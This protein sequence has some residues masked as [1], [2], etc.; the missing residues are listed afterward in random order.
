MKNA[1]IPGCD[2]DGDFDCITGTDF[3]AVFTNELHCAGPNYAPVFSRLAG[4]IGGGTSTG[5][6][7]WREKSGKQAQ[8]NSEADS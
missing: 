2:E 7:P 3:A 6:P 8:A 5:K 4:Q 1:G